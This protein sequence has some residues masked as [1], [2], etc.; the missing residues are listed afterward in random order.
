MPSKDR[1]NSFVRKNQEIISHRICQNIKP[2]RASLPPSTLKG[3]ISNIAQTLGDV[4]SSHIMN[5]DETNLQDDPGK[6][7]VISKRGI[8]FPERVMDFSKSVIS[9]MFAGF[10]DG[11]LLPPYVCYKAA[12]LYESWTVG[13]PPG[14]RYNCSASNWFELQTFKDWF[15]T[16]VLPYFLRLQGKKF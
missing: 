4:P 10:A 3:F 5:Y 1:A 12:H 13:G 7:K 11:T 14:T 2:T 9:V 6:K 16:I 15:E 8:K